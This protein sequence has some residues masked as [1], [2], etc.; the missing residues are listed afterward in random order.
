M[1]LLKNLNDFENGIELF[2]KIKSGEM[3]LEDA[4]ELQNIFKSNLKSNLNEISKGWFKSKE[5]KRTFE[6]IKLPYESWQ[7]AIKL[8]NDYSDYSDLM[9]A[10]QEILSP[11]QMLHRFPVALA[12]V[13]AG[14]TSENLLNQTNYLFFVPRKKITKKVCNNIMNSIKYQSRMGATFMNSENSKT[15]NPH[16]LLLNLSDKWKLKQKW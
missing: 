6:N 1:I 4:K 13:K 2:R 10:R 7:A 9:I 8:F 15:Y 5:Q 3:K 11:K 12:Q 16:R 14:N